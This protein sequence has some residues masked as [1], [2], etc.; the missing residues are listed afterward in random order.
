[1]CHWELCSPLLLTLV[2][3]LFNQLYLLTTLGFLHH[4]DS[5]VNLMEDI[6]GKLR[7]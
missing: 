1:M 4:T 7:I 3:G 6:L 2:R 5:T